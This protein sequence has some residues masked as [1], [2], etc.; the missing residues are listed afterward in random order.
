MKQNALWVILFLAGC[1]QT[2]FAT[3]V[4]AGAFEAESKGPKF[5]REGGAIEATQRFL[6]NSPMPDE[7]P[8]WSPDGKHIAFQRAGKVDA[9]GVPSQYNLWL[10]NADGGAQHQLTHAE[11][12]CQ[13]ASWSPDGKHIA[14]RQ[15]AAS[16]ATRE[17]DVA[18]IDVASGAVSLLV[19]NPGD[20]KHP[21]FSHDGKT[22]VWNS[23]REGHPANLYMLPT[24]DLKAAPR[25]LTTSSGTNDVHPTFSPDDRRV[26]FHSYLI[27]AAP[28]DNEPP[29]KLGLVE[30]KS[31]AQGWLDVGG[32]LAPKHPFFTPDGHII[33]FH[34]SDAKS[35]DSNVY[36]M[37]VDKPGHTVQITAIKNG[38]HPELSP[39]GKHLIYA[40]KHK[41]TDDGASQYDISIVDFDYAVL[42]H[43]LE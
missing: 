37:N 14:F 28:I 35:G 4:G 34:A 26:V 8:V 3:G 23:E 12:D 18:M 42:R 2:P 19:E 9:K 41:L 6:T 43:A 7:H 38:K 27:G 30:V 10:M 21:S 5:T 29:T 31:G 25:R 17:F 13:Q 1:H 39:D 36:A 24:A 20:D 15:A 33:T 11:R 22:L 40:H 32:L 16:G